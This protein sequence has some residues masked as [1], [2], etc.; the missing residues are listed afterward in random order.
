MSSGNVATSWPRMHRP[1][2]QLQLSHQSSHTRHCGE[3][4]RVAGSRPCT[5][6][7]TTGYYWWRCG[8]S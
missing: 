4:R 6:A 5:A 3:L 8:S 1:P 2:P 7:S